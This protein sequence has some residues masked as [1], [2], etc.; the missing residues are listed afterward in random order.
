MKFAQNMWFCKANFGGLLK[1]STWNH[2]SEL[3]LEGY[4]ITNLLSLYFT[5]QK[6]TRSVNSI[7]I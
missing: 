3:I 1:E 4:C 5:M 6:K 7:H 2:G